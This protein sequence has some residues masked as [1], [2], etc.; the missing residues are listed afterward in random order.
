MMIQST[1]AKVALKS[2][3][4]FEKSH[5]THLNKVGNFRNMFRKKVWYLIIKYVKSF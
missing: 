1:L 3:Y 4:I 2:L 5:R